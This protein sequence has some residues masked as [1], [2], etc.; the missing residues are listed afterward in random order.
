M[1]RARVT[2]QASSL[3][4]LSL[5]SVIIIILGMS[6][7]FSSVLQLTDL[8]DFIAPSQVTLLDCQFFITDNLLSRF[9]SKESQNF[10]ANEGKRLRLQFR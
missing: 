2:R 8:D 3:S 1:S 5:G 7:Q 4:T 9:G 6:H 10:S